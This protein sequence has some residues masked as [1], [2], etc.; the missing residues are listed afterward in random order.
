MQRDMFPWYWGVLYFVI[1]IATSPSWRDRKAD[2][3]Q[4]DHQNKGGQED[5]SP[6]D[7]SQAFTRN[8]LR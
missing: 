6:I 5:G 4:D 2:R 1:Y 7:M 8:I 3:G